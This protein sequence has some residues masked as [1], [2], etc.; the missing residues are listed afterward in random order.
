MKIERQSEKQSEEQR[1]KKC[2]KKKIEIEVFQEV[3][4]IAEERK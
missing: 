2:Y 1:K 4:F 3:Q